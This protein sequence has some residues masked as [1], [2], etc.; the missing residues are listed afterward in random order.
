MA[1]DNSGKNI[2]SASHH[3]TRDELI[4]YAHHTLSDREQHEM[5]KHLVD[6]LLCSDALKGIAEME[7]AS[8]LFNVSKELRHRAQRKKL[9]KKNIFSQ[10]ELI[11]IFAVV[12]LII[13]L[14]LITIFFFSRN[15]KRVKETSHDGIKLQLENPIDS[16]KKE[17]DSI[18]ENAD[19]VND[20]VKYILVK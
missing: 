1:S 10:N 17:Q 13:F 15:E 4:R 7:N 9:W 8:L 20:E 16:F 14:V 12:F 18:H 11:S 3:F 19:T 6:C 5:E 2:F